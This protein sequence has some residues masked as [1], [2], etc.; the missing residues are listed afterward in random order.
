MFPTHKYF[1]SGRGLAS[2]CGVPE[3]SVRR[4][5][6]GEGLKPL[7]SKCSLVRQNSEFDSH[8]VHGVYKQLNNEYTPI[9]AVSCELGTKI[10]QHYARERFTQAEV[11]VELLM[12]ESLRIR[13]MSAFQNITQESIDRVIRETNE[14]IATEAR[15][16]AKEEHNQWNSCMIQAGYEPALLHDTI[17]SVIF[18]YTANQARKLGKPAFSDPVWYD[19]TVGINYHS[20]ANKFRQYLKV[21]RQLIVE[22]LKRG[23]KRGDCFVMGHAMSAAFKSAGIQWEYTQKDERLTQEE[24]EAIYESFRENMDLYKN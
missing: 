1:Y 2:I 15:K 22:I 24:L 3:T 16:E 23:E 6:G 17:T 8:L 19:T 18:G 12:E 5:L 11:L 10:I 20:D 4:F 14:R 7:L 13:A 9:T 21:K